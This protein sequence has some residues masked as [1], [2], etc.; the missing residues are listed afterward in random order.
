MFSWK[1]SL[2]NDTRTSVLV[3]F[4]AVLSWPDI[5]FSRVSLQKARTNDEE[6]HPKNWS[7]RGFI[8]RNRLF[9]VCLGADCGILAVSLVL[10]FYRS[11]RSEE[12]VE[13]DIELPERNVVTTTNTVTNTTTPN[14]DTSILPSDSAGDATVV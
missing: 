8:W 11:R 10:A 4:C 12:L 2:E 6:N 14:L 9:V 5:I 7:Q 1:A 3:Y 13:S